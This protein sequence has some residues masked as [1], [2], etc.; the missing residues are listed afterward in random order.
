MERANQHLAPAQAHRLSRT[1]PRILSWP[2]PTPSATPPG[3]A[4]TCSRC[5]IPCPRV[6]VACRTCR[7][8]SLSLVLCESVLTPRQS[9]R[10]KAA[11]RQNEVTERLLDA[12]SNLDSSVRDGGRK[13][14]LGAVSSTARRLV[15]TFAGQSRRG[16]EGECLGEDAVY[17]TCKRVWVG[18]EDVAGAA[19]GPI[20]AM[21]DR[22]P[23]G[24]NG[25]VLCPIADSSRSTACL[26]RYLSNLP[27]RLIMAL[28][29]C[30]ST[31]MERD[32]L[33]GEE[34]TLRRQERLWP[35]QECK[36]FCTSMPQKAN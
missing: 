29:E 20:Q 21:L 12:V 8:P 23:S 2:L 27:R 34:N 10:R 3:A 5:K 11:D 7:G 17:M 25:P 14:R 9:T 19:R 1:R 24:T 15:R 33:G 18:A 36:L 22:K 32:L 30:V 6:P 35:V 13:T 16:L 28:G 26:G 31:I 4:A